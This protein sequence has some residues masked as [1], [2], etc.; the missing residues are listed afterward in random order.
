[1]TTISLKSAFEP[2]NSA[3]GYYSKS[4]ETFLN[5]R[6][7]I[8]GR[9]EQAYGK[10]T[11]PDGGFLTGSHLAGQPYDPSIGSIDLNSTDVLIPAFLAAYTGKNPRSAGLTAFPSLLKLLP[12][13]SIS[14]TGLMQMPFINKY[15]KS[16]SIDHV[17][18]SVYT[19]GAFNSFLNWVGING[20]S[21]LGYIQ[22]IASD[23][24]FPSSPYDITA[25]SITEAFKPLIG[26]NSTFLNNVS[27]K[28][29]Y[30]STRNVNL[31]VSSYQVGEILT[32]DFTFGTGYRI[33]NFN[34]ILKIKKTG[35][36]NFNNELVVKADVTYTKA[37]SLI[38]K[39]QDDFTQA[40]SGDT[41]TMIKLSAD[42][43][44]SKLVTLQ[45]YFDKQISKPLVSS[46]A[47]P[48]SKSSFG[49]SVTVNLTR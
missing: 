6:I 39:I 25:V 13:W 21:G 12:N 16:F 33:E 23:N 7:I 42:Y 35:G 30:N 15:F 31:N 40:I 2:V 1:M 5:N 43:N 17:Y 49:L 46:T 32:N 48:L 20:D 47:Y 4:F 18:S 41:R 9:L 27:L 3:N 8:A 26:I 19:V 36:T 28:L 22:S 10:S 14:Y 29:Q 38:R 24:P 11:Y 37:Q 44:L 34:K 45:A